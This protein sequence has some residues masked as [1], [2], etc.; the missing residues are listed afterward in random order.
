[1]R[2]AHF[3]E[4]RP[5][6][7]H[8]SSVGWQHYYEKWKFREHF[9]NKITEYLRI[10]SNQQHTWR[11]NCWSNKILRKFEQ[12]WTENIITIQPLVRISPSLANENFPIPPPFRHN[13]F[14]VE[15]TPE[16]GKIRTKTCNNLVRF[17]DTW[18]IRAKNLCP[19][20]QRIH[21][22]NYETG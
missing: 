11:G 15:R 10:S 20:I 6:Y 7:S 1:M 16:Q 13:I 9:S 5:P 19:S 21:Y 4:S 17:S 8:L 14:V 18:S 3:T 22:I 2:Y 12:P